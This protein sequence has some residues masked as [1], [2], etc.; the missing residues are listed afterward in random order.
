MGNKIFLIALLC[1]ALG[2][3]LFIRPRLFAPEP[4]PSLTDRLPESEVLGRFYLLDVARETS[5]M[6]FYH[7]IPFRDL[8]SYDF[9][10]SQAK[11]FGLDVQK[12][13]Y[14]FSDR[15]GEWGAFLHV[16]DSSRVPNGIARLQQFV[17]VQDSVVYQRKTHFL[18]KQNLFIFTDKSYMFVY[19]GAKFK[20]RLSRVLYAKHGDIGENWKLFNSL[21]TF[22]NEKLVVFSNDKKL[23]KYGVEYGLFAHDSDSL[24]FKLKAYIKSTQDIRIRMKENGIAFKRGRAFVILLFV[25]G[26]FPDIS[27]H[28]P[29][30]DEQ[31]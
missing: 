19:H 27:V 18:P 25:T 20:S 9:L 28:E 21:Q 12:P 31:G 5:S 11:S 6:L 16:T 30:E 23:R 24:S 10:L 1:A 26:H 13:G 22:R 14:F 15:E 3:F 29:A 8:V 2:L 7:K 17:D 4:R